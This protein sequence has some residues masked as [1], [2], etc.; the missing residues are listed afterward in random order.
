MSFDFLPQLPKPNLDDRKYNDLVE[1]CLLRIPRYCPEWTNH[2]PSDPGVTL[3]ELFAWLTDQMLFRFNQVPYRNYIVFLE[4]LGIRLQAPAPAQTALTFYLSQSQTDAVR[5]PYST[6]VATLRTESEP[7]IIFSTEQELV[8]GTPQIKHLLTA[9]VAEEHPQQWRDRTPPNHQWH[10]FEETQ[11]FE[12][13]T[14]GNCFYLALDAPDNSIQGN[15]VAINIKGVAART[16]GINPDDPP[17]QWQAW[18]GQEWEPI[19]RGEAD[20]KTRGF[21]FSEFN[22]A[23]QNSVQEGADVILHL[24]QRFPAWEFGAGNTHH[25]GHWIR[26]IYTSPRDLQPSYS[27]SPSIVGLSVRSIGGTVNASQC[28]RVERELLGVSNG[29][30][31][32]SFELQGKPVLERQS[33]RD[34][35][36]ELRLPTGEIQRWREVPDFADSGAEDPHYTLDSL[37]GTVQFGPLIREPAQLRQKTQ[38]RALQQAWQGPTQRSPSR[39]NPLETRTQNGTGAIAS[40]SE[41]LERQ[42]GKVP[43][44]GAEIYMVAYRTGGGSQ[45]NVQ[46]EKLTV[47]KS[48]IPYVKHVTNYGAAVGG[49]DAES[50]DEAVLRVPHLLRTRESAVIPEDFENVARKASRSVARAHCLSEAQTTPG[51]VRLLMVPQVSLET[52]DWQMGMHPDE[53]FTL[54][55][56]LKAEVLDYIRDRKPLGIQVHLQEPEYVGVS[57]RLKLLLDPSYNHPVTQAAIR[58][59]L[60]RALYRFLNPLTGGIDGRGWELGRP[61][62]PNDIVGLCQGQVMPGLRHVGFVELYELRKYGEEWFRSSLPEPAINPG[63]LGLICSWNDG[64]S[65]LRSHHVIEFAD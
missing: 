25:R 56:R 35:Y 49:V 63:S 2:N 1:E 40:L 27:S 16:T 17:R 59:Q 57:V 61:V 39:H 3:L 15:V 22:Q 38:Q 52:V 50:L 13:P 9:D 21:S 24:P 46:A 33:D 41:L 8:I 6:E 32:Q 58:E 19:L 47:L 20:D 53:A 43:P 48:A 14:P 12:Q 31:G 11:L 64:D 10:R 36:I 62:Y 23:A 45:G 55:E 42:Y 26:C 18:N 7:A 34:E 44:L 5:I 65:H 29:K 4:M 30:P 54:N 51:I 60:L 28:V 37:T